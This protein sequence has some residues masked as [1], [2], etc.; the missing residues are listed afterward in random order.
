[1]NIPKYIILL[2]LFSTSILSFA[3]TETITY[4]ESTEDIVNPD[5]GF[6]HPYDCHSSNFEP[7]VLSDLQSRRTTAFTPWQGNYS[8]RTSVIL[9]H[10]ILDSFV[11]TDD[12]STAFLDNVQADFDIARRCDFGSTKWFHWR[13]GRAVLHRLFWRC[14][15]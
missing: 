6:Y 1:M 7:F 2:L 10:Y 11:N 8:V 15:R 14:L 4:T 5:R 12:L 9:R 13:L 3:Q